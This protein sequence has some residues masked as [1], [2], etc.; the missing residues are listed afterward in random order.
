MV[1]FLMHGKGGKYKPLLDRYVKVLQETR[2]PSEAR[3]VFTSAD[4]GTI[5]REWLSYVKSLR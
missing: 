1:H 4:L 2:S 5:Q 3:A